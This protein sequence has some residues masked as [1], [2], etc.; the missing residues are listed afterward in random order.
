MGVHDGHR[1]RVKDRF[2]EAGATAFDDHNLLEL[3]LFYAVPRRDTN[4][5][6]HKLIERFGS[7]SAVLEASVDELVSVDGMGKSAAV[8]IKLVPEMNKR[9]M[10]RNIDVEG[11]IDSI[12]TAG[13]YFIAKFAYETVEVVYVMFLDSKNRIISC[14][15]LSR[16][17]VNGT[18]ISIRAI[19]EQALACKA[20]SVIV[21]HNHPEGIP[22]PSVEDELTTQKIKVA[23]STVGIRLIDHIVVGGEQFVSFADCGLMR[24]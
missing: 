11:T 21:A 14:R 19:A 23:L 9:Y 17:V 20:T 3:L 4:E 5:L 8:L 12:S 18:D 10:Q 1:Q 13:K 15:E 2:V 7:Y 24:T 16:G 22:I 6:A